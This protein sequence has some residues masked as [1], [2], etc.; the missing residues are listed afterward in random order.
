MNG[1]CWSLPQFRGQLERGTLLRTFSHYLEV[2]CNSVQDSLEGG[3]DKS[4]SALEVLQ[5]LW[6]AG[7]ALCNLAQRKHGRSPEVAVGSGQL[8][9]LQG[10][11]QRMVRGLTIAFLPPGDVQHTLE[12]DAILQGEALYEP[13]QSL[14]KALESIPQRSSDGNGWLK[15]KGSLSALARWKRASAG[16][17]DERLAAQAAEIVS[18]TAKER[19][20]FL[21]S[22]VLEC[23]ESVWGGDACAPILELLTELSAICKDPSLAPWLAEYRPLEVYQ[24]GR[25][26]PHHIVVDSQGSLWMTDFAK[27]GVQPLFADAATLMA[28]ILFE[29]MPIVR[30]SADDS[31]MGLALACEVVDTL[32]A[33][34]VDGGAPEIWHM[35]EADPPSKWPNYAAHVFRLA[36]CTLKL[37]LELA[38]KCSAR[39]GHT[40]AASDLHS[41]NMLL[42]LLDRSLRAIRSR[43]LST[44]QKRLAWHTSRMC[45]AQLLKVIRRAPVDSSVETSA[46]DAAVSQS[47]GALSLVAG[48]PVL[49]LLDADG[50]ILH[51]D[52]GSPLLGEVGS[53]NSEGASMA[54]GLVKPVEV[55]ITYDNI[56]Q[57]ALPWRPPTDADDLLVTLL[58]RAREEFAMMSH[59]RTTCSELSSGIDPHMLSERA[60]HVLEVSYQQ[61]CLFH[62]TP[63]PLPHRT[64]MYASHTLADSYLIVAVLRCAEPC[65]TSA[66]HQVDRPNCGV[67][68]AIA[69][70]RAQV[71]AQAAKAHGLDSRRYDAVGAFGSTSPAHR[72][73]P[74]TH[75]AHDDYCS[76]LECVSHGS[77]GL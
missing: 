35:V 2:E 68:L 13:P 42:P 26:D 52:E 22:F 60:I 14:R 65:A 56:S 53:P 46:A 21:H 45:A 5:E 77:E 47:R 44:D 61:R 51:G 48:H 9:L 38:T 28:A 49:L 34:E 59:L 76:A 17:S 27:A 39:V 4:V 40:S 20:A 10:H 18:N 66:R 69:Q 1:A 12:G 54:S 33:T 63:F 64:F 37:S 41:A 3:M 30:D 16:P 25:L 70:T 24:H 62:A 29:F 58:A 15:L 57:L 73:C 67:R 75:S 50:R 19:E 43:T 55:A 71:R 74:R 31:E 11:I 36:Q 23:E 8:G 6:S 72:A 7:G 32:F